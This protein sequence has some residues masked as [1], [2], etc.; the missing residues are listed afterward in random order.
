MQPMN[1][2]Y[3]SELLDQFKQEEKEESYYRQIEL[4]LPVMEPPQSQPI[5]DEKTSEEEPKDRGVAII[6]IYSLS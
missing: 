6:D 2:W 3:Y 1:E 4:E 5:G